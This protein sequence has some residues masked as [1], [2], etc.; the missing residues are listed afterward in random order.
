MQADFGTRY[1]YIG[2]ERVKVQV[3]VEVL[4]YSRRAYVKVFRQENQYA[5]F[6][7]LEEAFRYFGGIPRIVLVDNARPLV[8]NHDQVTGE[9]T[10]NEKYKTFAPYWK[11]I[12]KACRLRR[13]R[14]KGKVGRSVGYAKKNCIAGREFTSW[15]FLEGHIASWLRDVSDHMRLDCYDGRTP[16]GLFE[17]GHKL[18]R[19]LEGKP[20]FQQVREYTRRVSKD[21]Y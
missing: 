4:G 6:T 13:A 2:G 16:A 20:P 17:E 15:E 12:P 10:L 19:P 1:V 8:T 11:F 14:T 21:L 7:G 18:L 5:W 9:V 3:F